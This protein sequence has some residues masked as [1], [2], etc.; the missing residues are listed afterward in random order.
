[1][2]VPVPNGGDQLVTMTHA[3]DNAAMICAALGCDAAVGEAFNC[4]TSSLLSYDELA[5]LCAKAAGVDAKVEHYAPG[6]AADGFKFVE[7]RR[8]PRDNKNQFGYN[9]LYDAGKRT[10]MDI[11]NDFRG[12]MAKRQCALAPR[13]PLELPDAEKRAHFCRHK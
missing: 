7:V 10:N 9:A 5:G 3:A 4:A 6:A 1:M 11:R 12:Q 13:T 8:S 2:Q